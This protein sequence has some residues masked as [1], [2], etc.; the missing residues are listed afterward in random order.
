MKY[1][2]WI[3]G[4]LATFI[5]SVYVVVFT[6]FGNSLLQPIVEGKI[7]QQTK[8]DSKLIIFSLSM[9][10]FS[11]VLELDKNNI[12]YVNGNYSLFSQA[13][14]I[15]YRVQMNKLETLKPLTNAPMQG[16]F[17]VEGSAKGDLTFIEVDGKS[18]FASS[19][20]NFVATLKDFAS[21]SIKAKIKNLKLAKVL[22][23]FKQPHYADGV[24]SLDA[25]ISDARSGKLKGSV[26]STIN[27][28][29]L[30]SKQMTKA[31]KLKREMPHT[32]YKMNIYSTLDGN[33]IDSEIDL[34]SNLANLDIKRARV[35]L[36][37]G[38][39]VSDYKAKIPNLD[40]L[41]FV[42]EQHMK[43]GISIDGE[44][45]KA[46]DLDLSIHSKVA[47]G[48]I[49][50]L[51]HNDELHADIAAVQTLDALHML[52]YPE[53]FKASLNAKLDYNL[54][55]E[56]GELSGHLMDGKFTK[57]QIL[58]LV[59]QYTQVDLYAERFKGAVNAKINKEKILASLN[60]RSKTSSIKTK[61]TKINSKTKKI[62]SKIDID[63]NHN[64]ITV[65]LNGSISAPKVKID[66]NKLIKKEAE[67]AIKKEVGRL[68]RNLF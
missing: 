58:T 66:A 18:D 2:E 50:A 28:G 43:G 36:N 26:V 25:D 20:T 19:D 3:G 52:I 6:P 65:V 11:I 22:Y 53:I 68:L 32:T 31:Y 45:K 13:F 5:V 4:I 49:D 63:A 61:N 15:V 27:N 34:D 47:G 38:S 59:K 44:L 24:F 54:V 23:M 7:K 41:Y 42:T 10:D 56:K 29:L 37:N 8:L 30:D 64:P 33:I 67:K 40:K 60:I 12:I 16:V 48:K 1:L 55:S 39:L 14:N 9:S 62:N 46:K 17:Y 35:N 57:N 21:A 51:L